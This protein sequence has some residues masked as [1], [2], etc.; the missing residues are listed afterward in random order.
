MAVTRAR[1]HFT[2]VFKSAATRRSTSQ[3]FFN[4]FQSNI[5]QRF[6]RATELFFVMYA[7]PNVTAL[8]GSEK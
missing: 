7:T 1:I 4:S 2:C 6:E 3:V 8:E 5:D